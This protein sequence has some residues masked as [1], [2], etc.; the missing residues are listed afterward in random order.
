MDIGAYSGPGGALW[1]LDVDGYP[2]WWQPGPYDPVSYPALGLDCDDRD[3]AVH[4]GSGC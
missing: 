2:E 3:P 1:D 4:P